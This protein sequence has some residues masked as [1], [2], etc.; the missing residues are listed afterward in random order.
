MTGGLE[1]PPALPDPNEGVFQIMPPE[2]PWGGLKKR[3]TVLEVDRLW[4]REPKKWNCYLTESGPS[5]QETE[6][7]KADAR[8]KKNTLKSGYPA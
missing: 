2:M 4:R 1:D 7:E 3:P 8:E 6:P 5:G